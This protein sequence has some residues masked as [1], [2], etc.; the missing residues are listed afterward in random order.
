MSIPPIDVQQFGQSIW[1]DN[2][3]RRIIENGDLQKLVDEGGVVGLTSNP[4]IFQRAI[5]NTQDYDAAIR[6]NL[7]A[8]AA[9]IYEQLAIK[10]IQDAADIMRPVFDRTNGLDG[11]VS[12]EVS[13]LLANSTEETI[14]E[15]KRLFAA[16]DR[17]NLMIKI[18]GTTAGLPAIE[19]AIFAGLNI[20]V[21]LIF[22]VKNYELVA[23]AYMKGLERRMEAGLAV[24]GI[25]SVASIFVS[26]IDSSVDTILENNIRSAQGR[27]LERVTLNRKLLGKAAISNCKLA[28]RAYQRLFEGE[29]FAKLREAGAAVQRPLWASSATKNPNYPD[30]YYVD[31]LVGPNTV[32]TLPPNTLAAF[33]DHGT[34]AA[35]LTAGMEEANEVMRQLAELG[36]DMEQIT[37]QLQGD[38]V[39]QFIDSFEVLMDQV[40]AKRI[41]LKTGILDNQK[42]ALGVY[43]EK[44]ENA[45]HNMA[46]EHINARIWNKDASVWKDNPAIMATINNRLGWLDVRKT[47]DLERLQVLQDSVKG[48]PFEHVVLLGMGGSS[49]APEVLFKTFGQQAGFPDLRVLDNT[50]P[51]QVAAIRDAVNLDKTLFIVASKSGGTIETLSFFRYFWE[52]T[53]GKGEQFI[54]ITD[55]GS[56]LEQLATENKFRHIFI[57]P[58]D[59]GGR[60]SALSYFGL[61]PAAL[62]GLD[63]QAFWGGATAMMEANG[64][65]IPATY[66]PGLWLGV[67][68]GQLAIEGRDKLMIFASDGIASFGDWAEQLVA[69][70]TG[71]EGKGVLPV[72][73]A[74]VGKPHDYATDRVFVYLKLE[75][76]P[77]NEALDVAVRALREAG[78]PRITLTLPNKSALAGEFFRWAYATGIAGKMLNIN[79]FDEPNVSEAKAN[80][81]ALLAQFEADGALPT[82]EAAM[83]EGDV[84]LFADAATLKP[85]TELCEAHAFNAQSLV[86]MVAARIIGTESGDYFALLSYARVDDAT[87][88]KMQ[89]VQRRL[90]HATRRAATFNY[91][92]RYLHSTGQLHKG[93]P[94]KGIF[95]QFTHDVSEVIAIPE[96]P[97]DFGTLHAAQAAGDV[98][99]LSDHA[100]RAVR[101]H[102]N[103]DDIHAALDVMLAALDIVESRRA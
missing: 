18:P 23:E 85:L 31:T 79:P 95:F 27:D 21:T 54:A 53:G 73:G 92:P 94:N 58:S 88:A 29:R 68:M 8:D 20:N 4:A 32:N 81:N 102:V 2:I 63:L 67:V 55:E 60:Y 13:P 19:E 87:T 7:D 35:T 78:H 28:Y 26:R 9:D 45:L 33:T 30:T 57:N 69:E 49:L 12:L 44:V 101:L 24:S 43:R 25:A 93:G 37:R 51:A 84:S 36:I 82:S 3:S 89:E 91:G 48:G 10:D 100:C 5:G 41:S 97:Y 62:I 17:P 50:N 39:E 61:V 34:A 80:T 77:S 76:D 38:G 75:G 47:I 15:A 6:Q 96:A 46:A 52:L 98:K 59:I 99:A 64:E 16:V 22:S 74:T 11:Y 86:E 40:E 66:H 71:K 83:R 103:G 72:V 42:L 90:R 70:S 14:T 56:K 65:R 1:T